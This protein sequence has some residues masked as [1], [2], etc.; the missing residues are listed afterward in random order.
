MRLEKKILDQV[1]RDF[2]YQNL[3]IS[4]AI[5][6]AVTKMAE[7]GKIDDWSFQQETQLLLTKLVDISLLTCTVYVSQLTL[8]FLK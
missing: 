3:I 4:F 7:E 6:V 1:L 5:V 2:I 8:L